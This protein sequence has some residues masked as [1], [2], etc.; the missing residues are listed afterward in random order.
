MNG[1]IEFLLVMFVRQMDTP[2]SAVKVA[3]ST[4][5]VLRAAVELPG[6]WGGVGPG[7]LSE[8]LVEWARTVADDVLL[9]G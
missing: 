6:R 8:R 7:P 9:S 1:S 5:Q 2:V 4:P 3:C